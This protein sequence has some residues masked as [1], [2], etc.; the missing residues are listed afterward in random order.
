[1]HLELSIGGRFQMAVHVQSHCSDSE[2]H[3]MIGEEP[4]WRY[5]VSLMG[6]TKNVSDEQRTVRRR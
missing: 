1:M 3:N 2:A 6:H 5:W 4:P